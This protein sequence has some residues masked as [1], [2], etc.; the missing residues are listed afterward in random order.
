[1]QTW[2]RAGDHFLE[3][4]EKHCLEN[5]VKERLESI[6]GTKGSYS[7]LGEGVELDNGEH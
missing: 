4:L 1:M 6:V 7:Q 3:P 2:I 5:V